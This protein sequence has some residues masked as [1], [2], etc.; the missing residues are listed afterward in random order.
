MQK[1]RYRSGLLG[2]YKEEDGGSYNVI[3]Q[4]ALT[5]PICI[6]KHYANFLHTQ[7]QQLL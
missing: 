3:E 4:I 2:Y 6:L 5:S 7:A 1:I